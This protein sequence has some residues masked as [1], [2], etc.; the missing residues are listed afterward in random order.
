[1]NLPAI[2]DRIEKLREEMAKLKIYEQ[3]LRESPDK[4]LSLSD[5]DSR[6]MKTRGSAM[7]GYN[8]QTAVDTTHHLIVAHEVVND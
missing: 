5:P 7:V 3:A 2:K 1:M 6:T 8:V 4:Q